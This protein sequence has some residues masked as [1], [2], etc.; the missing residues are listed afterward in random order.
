MKKTSKKKTEVSDL[1]YLDPRRGI[2][3]IRDPIYQYI[4]FTKPI[5]RGEV[6]EQDIINNKWIQRLKRIFQTQATWSS[7]PGAVHTRFSHSLGTMHLT[8]EFVRPLYT[9]YFSY[10]SR[11]HKNKFAKEEDFLKQYPPIEYVVEVFR[12]AG[13]LHDV[14]HGPMSH[15][16]DKYYLKNFGL[17]HEI[18]GKEI[19]IRYFSELIANIK[20]S[21]SEMLERKIKPQDV[22]DVLYP[23][24]EE[25]NLR[26]GLEIWKTLLYKIIS[27]LYSADKL[28]YLIR[29]SYF[30][31]TPELAIIDVK[32]LILTSMLTDKGLTLHLSSKDSSLVTFLLSRL[33]MYQAVYYHRYVRAFE[34]SIDETIPRI[35]KLIKLGDPRKNLEKYWV[36]DDFYVYSLCK[37]WRYETGI[38]S[39][40]SNIWLSALNNLYKWEEVHYMPIYIEKEWPRMLKSLTEP[41]G[42][43]RYL[44]N[45]LQQVARRESLPVTDLLV[46]VPALDVRPENPWGRDKEQM[47]YIY[48]PFRKKL[49][50]AAFLDIIKN[51]PLKL[52]SARFFCKTD[53][54]NKAAL[55]RICRNLF[56]EKREDKI[57]IEETHM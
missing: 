32:R 7:Y 30:C 41:Q 54:K 22:I 44:E 11:V 8:T 33:Y 45:E 37:V 16:F 56:G 42:L 53:S 3:F 46:D 52:I 13:L 55:A 6:S 18:L 4:P 14:G 50:P 27:G 57:P 24:D 17:N 29:D 34:L 47:I 40:I 21:P 39:E 48:D 20:R 25:G 38:K 36:I 43:K 5:N 10:A 28:D 2:D 35:M 15:A 49:D 26:P 1:S 19:I 31:G 12:L 9:R 51:L 23:C